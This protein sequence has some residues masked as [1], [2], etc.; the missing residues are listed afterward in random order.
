MLRQA[1]GMYFGDNSN[2]PFSQV[3]SLLVIDLPD[4]YGNKF[5]LAE[6]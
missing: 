6:I 3:L 1:G 5:V 2:G 4:F